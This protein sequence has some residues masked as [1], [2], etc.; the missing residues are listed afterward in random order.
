MVPQVNA[1]ARDISFDFKDSCNC[2]SC[3]DEFP[4]YVNTQGVVEKF[5]PQKAQDEREA[6]RRSISHLRAIIESREDLHPKASI[7]MERS[8]SGTIG[9]IKED[10]PRHM[11]YA[12]LKKIKRLLDSPVFHGQIVENVMTGRHSPP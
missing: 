4:V 3:D 6:L 2:C 9:E 8:L 5:N 10:S 11:S 12:E 1:T 7:H